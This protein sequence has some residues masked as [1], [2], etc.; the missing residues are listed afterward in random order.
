M[1]P[2]YLNALADLA[3]PDELWKLTVF[4]QIKLSPE[5]RRQLD[6]G[7]ALRRHSDH[8]W[9]LRAL[10]DTGKSL[11]LTPLSVN[12]TD[13]RT[14]PTPRSIVKRQAERKKYVSE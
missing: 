4:V 8:I 14:I 3:D 11:L 9:R 2:D 5:K 6:T 1:T 7:V 12:G 13:V 10:L